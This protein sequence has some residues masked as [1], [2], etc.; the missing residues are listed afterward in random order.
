V[1]SRDSSE[2]KTAVPTRL[3]LGLTSRTS[4]IQ[5]VYR[6]TGCLTISGRRRLELDEDKNNTDDFQFVSLDHHTPYMGTHKHILKS[7][8]ATKKYL[9][10]E[11]LKIVGKHFETLLHVAV[12]EGSTEVVKLLQGYLGPNVTD[13]LGHTPLHYAARIGRLDT[14]KVLLEN[15]ANPNAQNNIGLTPLHFAVMSGKCEAVE[16]LLSRGADPNVQ[17]EFGNTPLHI[18]PRYLL[19]DEYL[20]V[21]ESLLTHGANANLQNN[22]GNTP[23]HESLETRAGEEMALLLL[24]YIKDVDVRNSR[25]QTPLHIATD[26][27]LP[28]AI[29]KLLLRGADPNARDLHGKTPLHYA[30]EHCGVEEAMLLLSWGADA[31]IKDNDGNTP[32]SLAA[33]LASKHCESR[34]EL[35][36]C[37]PC[38]ELIGIMN[39][40]SQ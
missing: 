1:S 13:S 35:D 37:K 17:D 11:G 9:E 23:L 40:G 31:N 32:A 19:P 29:E 5:A 8:N 14:M 6:L 38:Q 27:G 7:V 15:G 33:S 3:L 25:G 10:R 22:Y 12:V 16:M 39:D 28:S 2:I 4:S 18:I 36:M 30:V 26:T 21:V 20:C 24:E 34:D